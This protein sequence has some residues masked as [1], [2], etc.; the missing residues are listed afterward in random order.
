MPY[1]DE[2]MSYVS[3]GQDTRTR[4]IIIRGTPILVQYKAMVCCRCGAEI[5]D[6]DQE[7]STMRRARS[8]Y[9]QKKKMLPAASICAYMEKNH[10]S[11]E[12]MAV[13]AGCAENEIRTAAQGA[14]LDT[15]TDSKIRRAIFA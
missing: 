13:L 3:V 6:G 9:R 12:Q 4:T 14:L 15:T 8:I 5:F 1:C 2:C 10:L 11:P 7:I